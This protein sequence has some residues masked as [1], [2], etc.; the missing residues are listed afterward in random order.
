MQVNSLTIKP[1]FIISALLLFA[2]STLAVINTKAGLYSTA[3]VFLL[4]LTLVNPFALYLLFVSSFSIDGISITQDTSLTKI[5]GLILIAG[6]GLRLAMTKKG[7]VPDNTYKFFFLFLLGGIISFAHS[8]NP[9][10]SLSI[11]LTYVSLFFLYIVTRYFSTKI[12]DVHKALKALFWGT[13]IIYVGVKLLSTATPELAGRFGSGMVDPNEFASFICVLIPLTL[14]MANLYKGPKKFPYLA[15][16]AFFIIMLVISDSRGGV[17]GFVGE[18]AVLLFYSGFKKKKQIAIFLI[19]ASFA[20]YFTVNHAFLQ[21]ADTI[22]YPSKE[23]GTSISTRLMNYNAAIKIFHDYPISGVG[24]YNFQFKSPEYGGEQLA[25]HNTYLEILADGGLAF[26]LP[27]AAILLDIWRKLTIKKRYSENI[28]TILIYLKSSYVS[29]LITSFFLS[30]DHKKILW[31]LLALI[32]S[33]YYIANGRV[34]RKMEE[35]RG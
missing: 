32:S 19:I 25:V 35:V 6:L 11:Y 13:A 5:V 21:R 18:T 7:L 31:F 20:A 12:E 4:L 24:I 26:F 27:F 28:K 9:G 3:I 15:L 2:L 22:I 14:Y 16:I 33:I 34:N 10:V 23:K 8:V 30:A 29:I 17:L 1:H